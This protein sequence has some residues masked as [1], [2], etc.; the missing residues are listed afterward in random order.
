[1]RWNCPHCGRSLHLAD[2]KIPKHWAFSKCIDCRGFALIR[3]G[4]RN[5]I[6]VDGTP[7]DEKVLASEAYTVSGR[8]EISTTV[9]P[10]GSVIAAAAP[11]MPEPPLETEPP[12]PASAE[13]AKPAIKPVTRRRMSLAE[14]QAAAIAARAA[15]LSEIAAAIRGN[16]QSFPM[17]LPEPPFDSARARLVPILAGLFAAI[18]VGAAF[19][20]F[21]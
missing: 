18:A 1:M 15:A 17:P 2:K 5:I 9:Q 6:K 3:N 19:F 21:F 20:H 11:M 14:M 13:P 12:S 10:D 16:T 8:T 7:A 4:A